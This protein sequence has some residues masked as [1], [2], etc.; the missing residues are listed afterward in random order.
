M[1]G[2]GSRRNGCPFAPAGG[3]CHHPAAVRLPLFPLQTVLFPYLPLP[4]H[5]FE[6]RYRAM[7]DDLLAK[8]EPG[9]RRFVVA[10]IVAGSEIAADG[11]PPPTTAPV[12]TVAEVRRVDELNSGRYAVL[13]VGVERVALG[14]VER[15]GAYALV[16]AVPLPEVEGPDAVRLLPDVQAALDGYLAGVKRYVAAAASS[17]GDVPTTDV[18]SSLDRLLTPIRLPDDPLAASYAVAGV[19]QVELV[20][21]QHLLELPD[22]ASR[23]ATELDLLRRETRLLADGALSPLSPGDL[24]YSPN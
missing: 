24:H 12:G 8:P 15:T 20:H 17:G 2:R 11:Q 16:E 6:P 3:A 9:E 1:P 14:E 22:A 18:A 4:L 13:A 7:V 5:V 10:R 23:L 19:L 21:K